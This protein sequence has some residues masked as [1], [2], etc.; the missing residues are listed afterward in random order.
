M[1]K[2]PFVK[3][4]LGRKSFP[5]SKEKGLNGRFLSIPIIQN[6]PHQERV[7][8]LFKMEEES[9]SDPESHQRSHIIGLLT[10]TEGFKNWNIQKF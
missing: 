9:G 1:G 4:G 2:E 10:R 7:L 8:T 6:I 3:L 5:E